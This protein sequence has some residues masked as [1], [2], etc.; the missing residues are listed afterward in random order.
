MRLIPRSF[1]WRT[2]LM[3]LI[4]LII[5]EVIIANVFFG[6]HWTRVHATLARSLAVEISTMMNFMDTGNTAAART[7]ARDMGINISINPKLTRPAHNDNDS[8]EAG[9][10]AEALS[11]RLDR[12]AQI[13]IDKGK[14]LVFI[15][16]PNDNNQ[17]VTFGTS[18]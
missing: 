11:S 3:I 4:P 14:R 1:L 8:R 6:N 9:L 18:L 5:A 7:M 2:I 16:I 17:I 12:P 10:L 15:D 13:Y